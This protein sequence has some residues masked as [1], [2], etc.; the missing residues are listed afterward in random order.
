MLFLTY[1]VKDDLFHI[2]HH[3]LIFEN[4]KGKYGL[5]RLLWLFSNAPDD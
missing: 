1:D 2:V 4:K 3:D 5:L